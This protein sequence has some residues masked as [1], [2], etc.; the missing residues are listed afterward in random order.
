[1]PLYEYVCQ[2]CTHEFETLVFNEKKVSCPQCHGEHLERLLSIPAR[3]P[4]ESAPL[5]GAC[6]ST[7]PPCGSMCRRF[8]GP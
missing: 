8:T 5:P 6:N 7:G 1:M 2:D 4:A 3:P